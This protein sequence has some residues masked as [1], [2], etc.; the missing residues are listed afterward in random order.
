MEDSGDSKIE[1]L[2]PAGTI[3]QDVGRLQIAV[4]DQVPMRV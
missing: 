1:E 4:N 2:G 3:H